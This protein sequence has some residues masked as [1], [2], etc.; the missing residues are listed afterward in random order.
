E[1]DQGGEG[2]CKKARAGAGPYK[3]ASFTPGVE[4]QLEAFDG[5]WRKAP[6][7]KRLVFPTLPDETTRAAALKRGDVDIAYFLNGP[8]AEEVR[9][10]P[11][12]RLMAVRSNTVF[13]LDFRSQWEAGEPGQDGGGRPAASRG[14]D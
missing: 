1:G 11:G 7:V 3:V 12:L 10:T 9:R 4:L 8:V 13:F 6:S 2:G 5:Y 14:H